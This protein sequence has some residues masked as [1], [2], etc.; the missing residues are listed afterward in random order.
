MP[1]FRVGRQPGEQLGNEKSPMP[2]IPMMP[3]RVPG[4]SKA[5]TADYSV[6]NVPGP[7]PETEEGMR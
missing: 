5:R 2:G 6:G 4:R 7:S 3:A 1:S